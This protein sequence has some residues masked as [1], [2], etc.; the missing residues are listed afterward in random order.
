V[1]ARHPAEPGC[2]LF[3]ASRS[4]HDP[5]RFV[6]YGTYSFDIETELRAGDT[7]R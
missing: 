7:A 4:I 5:G 3:G 2:L 1:L 6:L